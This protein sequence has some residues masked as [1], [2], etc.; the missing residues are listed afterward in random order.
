MYLDFDKFMLGYK[1]ND[2]DYGKSHDVKK[3]RYRAAVYMY[4]ID[5][6]ITLELQ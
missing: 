5:C 1:I 6:C 4:E 2:I 3:G